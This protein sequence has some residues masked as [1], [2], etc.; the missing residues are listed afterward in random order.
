M[1]RDGF[2]A[3]FMTA[4]IETEGVGT[5]YSGTAIGFVMIFLGNRQPGRPRAGQQPGR[6]GDRVSPLCFWAALT[7][8]GLLG[9]LGSRER[10]AA[11]LVSAMD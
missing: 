1:V 5:A 4:I 8:L 9:L 10:R 6:D 7:G 2:M 11:A 3:V